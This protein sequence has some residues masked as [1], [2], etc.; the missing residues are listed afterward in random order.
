MK[1]FVR[2]PR[3]L[4]RCW[5][6]IN[7]TSVSEAI[8]PEFHDVPSETHL[9]RGL[10]AIQAASRDNVIQIAERRRQL[11]AIVSYRRTH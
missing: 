2:C 7:T 1:V 11:D 10:S 6:W 8:S 9:L 4:R 5:I 3:L